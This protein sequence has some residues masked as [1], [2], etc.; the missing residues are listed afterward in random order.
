MQTYSQ[1]CFSAGAD[2]G[3]RTAR[4][5]TG[6]EQDAGRGRGF[7]NSSMDELH[8]TY[9]LSKLKQCSGGRLLLLAIHCA[10]Q[11][12]KKVNL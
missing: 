12:I 7:Q 10:T 9:G 4:M 1:V 3:T 8:R 5:S 2:T 6:G 11:D